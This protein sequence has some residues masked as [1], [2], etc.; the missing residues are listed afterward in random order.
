MCREWTEEGGAG[1]KW[2]QLGNPESGKQCRTEVMKIQTSA[3]ALRV[4]TANSFKRYLGGRINMTQ[5]PIVEEVTWVIRDSGVI[6]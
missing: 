2:D 5:G 6:I 4:E 3:M 1:G